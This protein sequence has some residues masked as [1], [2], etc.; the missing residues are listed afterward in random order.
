VKKNHGEVRARRR[1]ERAGW[2]SCCTVNGMKPSVLAQ[3]TLTAVASSGAPAVTAAG[4]ELLLARRRHNLVETPQHRPDATRCRGCQRWSP[5]DATYAAVAGAVVVPSAAAIAR[6]GE[7]IPRRGSESVACGSAVAINC[8]GRD[9]SM[10]MLLWQN[11]ASPHYC[12]LNRGIVSLHLCYSKKKVD[13][14]L[15]RAA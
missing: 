7:R 12:S 6:S 9:S 11:T 14:N 2:W 4:E 10:S 8:V 15:P 13:P 5:H 3:G 1:L